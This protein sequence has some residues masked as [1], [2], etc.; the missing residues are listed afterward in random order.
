[1]I[2]LDDSYFQPDTWIRD[3]G[4]KNYNR[5]NNGRS[6]DDYLSSRE[7]ESD[8]FN[9]LM[10]SIRKSDENLR[11]EYEEIDRGYHRI[12]VLTNNI[13]ADDNEGTPK[14]KR[15]AVET[16]ELLLSAITY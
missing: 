5:E 7:S 9:R 6:K 2:G 3:G 14:E 12:M 11:R 15:S 10:E 13:K 4:K 1:M 16:L 8:R